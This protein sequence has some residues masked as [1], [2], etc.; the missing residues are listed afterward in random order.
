METVLP[1]PSGKTEAYRLIGSPVL[2]AET[3]RFSRIAYAAAHVVAD[4]VAMNCL[5]YTSP[6]P[7]DS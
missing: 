6:S 7:R 3:V 1:L 2:P 5:L 4:P